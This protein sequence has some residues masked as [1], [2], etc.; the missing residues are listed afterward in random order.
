MFGIQS[1]SNPFSSSQRA[2]THH[3]PANY[4]SD[5][6]RCWQQDRIKS[7]ESDFEWN[8]ASHKAGN[9][10]FSLMSHFQDIVVAAVAGRIDAI[11]VGKDI[12]YKF[13]QPC[14]NPSYRKG[15]SIEETFHMSLVSFN[16]IFEKIGVIY[17]SKEAYDEARQGGDPFAGKL[18]LRYYDRMSHISFYLRNDSVANKLFPNTRKIPVQN[19]LAFS[20]VTQNSSFQERDLSASENSTR[21]SKNSGSSTKCTNSISP[22]YKNQ[23]RNNNTDLEDNP[24]LGSR[25]RAPED[26]ESIQIEKRDEEQAS[27]AVTSPNDKPDSRLK[28]LASRKSDKETVTS[29][30][31]NTRRKENKNVTIHKELSPIVKDM[32]SIWKSVVGN[33]INGKDNVVSSHNAESI[34]AIFNQN[35]GGNIESWYEFCLNKVAKSKWLMGENTK[36]N[37][38]CAYLVWILKNIEVVWEGKQYD[39]DRVIPK[40]EAELQIEARQKEL[41]DQQQSLLNRKDGLHAEI[42]QSREDTLKKEIAEIGEEDKATLFPDFVKAQEKKGQ[43]IESSDS[44]TPWQDL[45]LLDRL[46]W[47]SALADFVR[48]RL[49]SED[50]DVVVQQKLLEERV[51]ERLGEV[52]GALAALNVPQEVL[53]AVPCGNGDVAPSSVNSFQ[54]NSPTETALPQDATAPLEHPP[55]S[56][57]LLPEDAF[58]S[59]DEGW[60]EFKDPVEDELFAERQE[61]FDDEWIQEYGAH[62]NPRDCV[63]ETVYSQDNSTTERIAA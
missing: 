60:D 29:R 39:L 4:V 40:T 32:L 46:L 28:S 61:I 18:Y 49:F 15:D 50:I 22:N 54:Q 45:N 37:W 34:E 9:L 36:A 1:L 47:E 17:N 21:P 20:C 33:P 52:T 6:P 12:F 10:N 41:I 42:R 63:E 26:E 55:A 14:K 62:D 48:P 19:K 59:E 31:A 5:A 7:E 44:P 56:V 35:C 30:H 51:E 58:E 13:G 24:I 23:F 43:R 8:D 53:G 2:A 27:P 38:K 25:A 11:F 16:R 57:D 3:I